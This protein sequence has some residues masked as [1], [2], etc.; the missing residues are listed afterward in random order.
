MKREFPILQMADSSRQFMIWNRGEESFESHNDKDIWP[1]WSRCAADIKES[2]SNNLIDYSNNHY[3]DEYT[4]SEYKEIYILQEYEKDIPSY[5]KSLN[6]KSVKVPKKGNPISILGVG[7]FFTFLL[8]S[9]G[10]ALWEYPIQPFLGYL[11]MV[12]YKSKSQIRY[13]DF[14]TKA[15]GCLESK[16]IYSEA[17]VKYPVFQLFVCENGS[18]I[19]WSY[20]IKKVHKTQDSKWVLE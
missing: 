9:A 17:S 10:S 2:I 7:I 5:I 16:K 6:I 12:E 18:E 15:G 13:E 19:V 14:L 11:N 3:I 8:Y 20:G 1:S 4:D